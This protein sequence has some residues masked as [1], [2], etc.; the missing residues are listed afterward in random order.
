ME[1]NLTFWVDGQPV[2]LDTGLGELLFWTNG[3]PYA[4]LEGEPAVTYVSPFP[5]F[6][7]V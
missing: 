2:L 4:M 3:Q 6:R 7:R 5:A 1:G